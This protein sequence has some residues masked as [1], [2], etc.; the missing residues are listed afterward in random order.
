LYVVYGVFSGNGNIQQKCFNLTPTICKE[1]WVINLLLHFGC[2]SIT[3]LFHLDISYRYQLRNTG[4]PFYIFFKS[5]QYPPVMQRD[6]EEYGSGIYTIG[7]GGGD[8]DDVGENGGKV[9]Q[10][11]ELP[12]L[13]LFSSTADY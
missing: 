1:C 6:Q 4:F 2:T 12:G 3:G 9:L 13:R 7:I 8:D 10:K 5:L 11:M